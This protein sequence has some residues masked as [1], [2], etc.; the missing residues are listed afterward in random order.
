MRWDKVGNSLKLDASS[1]NELKYFFGLRGGC[2]INKV[3]NVKL[4][5]IA[6]FEL[7]K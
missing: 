6:N 1:N 7:I 3:K 4:V 2:V 5:S